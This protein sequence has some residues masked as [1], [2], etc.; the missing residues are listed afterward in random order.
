M[1][2]IILG[3]SSPRRRSILNFFSIPF[4]VVKSDAEE[5]IDLTMSD[6]ALITCDLALKKAEDIVK[7]HPNDIILTADTI[8]YYDNKILLKP[9]NIQQAKEMLSLLSGSQHEVYTGVCVKKGLTHETKAQST[10]VYFNKLSTTQID[11]YINSLHLLD[12]AGSYNI[13]TSGSIV[14]KKI[15]GC[16]YNIIGL[17]ITVVCELLGK[18]GIDLWDYLKD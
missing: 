15:E 6:P 1:D 9:K 7:T 3:S 17:P 16:F 13:H 18:F 5:K 8:V 10:K 2:K 12:K 14:L 11:K 4:E